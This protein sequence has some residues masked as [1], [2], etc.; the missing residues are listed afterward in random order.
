M[1]PGNVQVIID[2]LQEFFKV[3]W[4]GNKLLRRT[5]YIIFVGNV[6]GHHN[7]RKRGRIRVG[8]NLVANRDPISV[9]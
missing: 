8:F 5:T 3:E 2:A 9:R 4:F 7:D 6:S 1:W